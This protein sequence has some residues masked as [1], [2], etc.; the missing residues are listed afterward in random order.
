M[1]KYLDSSGSELEWARR[2][3]MCG[4]ERAERNWASTARSMM[5]LLCSSS[6]RSG[7]RIL[8]TNCWEG[9]GVEFVPVVVAV[10]RE[11]A[12]DEEKAAAKAARD[13][14]S[15]LPVS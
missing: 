10:E 7:R 11:E 9:E 4:W 14:A 3:S 13:L 15:S 12:S 1:T 2:E 5:P 8:S 6:G